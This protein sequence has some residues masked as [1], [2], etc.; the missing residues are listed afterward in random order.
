[1]EAMGGE[2]PLA[3]LGAIR[4]FLYRLRV[5]RHLLCGLRE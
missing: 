2:E 5:A 4:H 3:P 1:M